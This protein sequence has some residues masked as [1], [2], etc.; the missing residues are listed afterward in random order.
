MTTVGVVE[1][2]AVDETGGTNMTVIEGGIAE[3]IAIPAL[4]R[5]GETNIDVVHQHLQETLAEDIHQLLRE[6][7]SRANRD[8]QRPAT[9]RKRK[10]K[11]PHTDDLSR[12]SP[13]HSSSAPSA[14]ATSAAAAEPGPELELATSPVPV[15]LTLAARRAKR[16]A[17]LAKYAGVASVNTTDAS[18]SP[19]PSI[20]E[21][22]CTQRPGNARCRQRRYRNRRHHY[23]RLRHPHLRCS[24]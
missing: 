2:L 20:A 23:H 13:A 18:P 24:N 14:P 5:L 7:L 17:I 15:E 10:A 19:G 22:P 16:Q 21:S 3:M 4:V 8:V 9:L 6:T 1:T 11:T 12:R